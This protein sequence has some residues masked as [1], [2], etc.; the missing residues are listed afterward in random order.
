MPN[1][2]PNYDSIRLQRPPPE[3][4][5]RY[6]VV[7]S[8]WDVF[9][10]GRKGRLI[11]TLARDDID[12]FDEGAARHLWHAWLA[13]DEEAIPGRFMSRADAL[14]ALVREDAWERREREGS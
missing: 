5:A 9:E 6:G 13:G 8:E 14:D 10:R 4:A 7:V 3:R 2:P 11:G 1:R 12:P